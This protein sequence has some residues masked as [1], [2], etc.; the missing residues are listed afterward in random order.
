MNFEENMVWIQKLPHAELELK[1]EMFL[2][3]ALRK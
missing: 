3:Q 2:L 1:Y